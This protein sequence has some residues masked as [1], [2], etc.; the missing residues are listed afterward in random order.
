MKHRNKLLIIGLIGFVIIVLT[1]SIWGPLP[2][3]HY[4]YPMQLWVI[5][6][7]SIYSLEGHDYE[8]RKQQ[9]IKGISS[10]VS[11]FP[12]TTKIIIVEN[13]GQQATYLDDFVSDNTTVYYTSTNRLTDNVDKSFKEKTDISLVIKEF[14]IPNDD[15]IV[16]V[17]GRYV[18]QQHSP[19]VDAVKNITPEIQ[20]LLRY[21]SYAQQRHNEAPDMNDSNTGLVGLRCHL[22][23]EVIDMIQITTVSIEHVVPKVVNKLPPSS[24]VSL[25]HLGISVSPGGGA[26]F[27]VV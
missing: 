1:V 3:E 2:E 11:S 25:N 19:F 16:K 15:F 23:K 17:T 7:T 5:V 6:S 22:W 24:V 27:Y 21:G 20:A 13:N 12:K 26:D 4:T 8:V 18:I 10:I 9:Y 14:N